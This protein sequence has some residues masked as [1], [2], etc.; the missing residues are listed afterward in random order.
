MTASP[1]DLP[2]VNRTFARMPEYPFVRLRG[3]LAPIDPPAGLTPLPLHAG[4][5]QHPVPDFVD[6]I[7]AGHR[8]Q[9]HRYPAVEG[10]EEFRAACAGWLSRRYGVS[11]AAIDADRTICPVNGT[12]EGLFI[13]T[14]LA[15]HDPL[16]DGRPRAV[17]L[18]NPFYPVYEGA[19]IIPGS[20][21]VYMH[22][23]PETG[24]LPDLDALEA[25]QAEDGLLDRAS[26]MYFCNPSNPEGMCASLGYL[27]RLIGLAR[28]HAFI[29]VLD[30][31]YAEIYD[32]TPPVGGL[33]AMAAMDGGAFDNV[34][35]FHSL[36]KR[37]NAAGLR[38]G[39]VFGDP[40]LMTV[41]RRLRNFSA[42]AMP[43]PIQAASAALW[44]DDAHVV[45]TRALYRAKFDAAERVIGNRYGFRR[46]DGGFFLWLDVGD[47]IEA[48]RRLWQQAAVRV[49]PGAFM[50]RPTEQG[51]NPG[52]GFIRVAVVHDA[53]VVTEA[54]GRMVEVL[55]D[56]GSPASGIATKTEA[57][58]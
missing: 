46:P 20:E 14:L 19:A 15:P 17:L 3:L 48:T 38:T 12:R 30:E 22:S 58:A 1:F 49:M 24:F 36:S 13:T 29:L 37:S 45:E 40:R 25:R 41:F 7:L 28:K 55:G 53:D 6:A 51:D 8:D 47:G 27:Q 54:M 23:R 21:P 10:T 16:P 5:P 18:P 35:I 11:E 56:H 42:P 57:A 50:T 31:C 44:R 33:E 43:V 34:L 52:A 39:F 32:R 26:L 4:D 9:L 2:I